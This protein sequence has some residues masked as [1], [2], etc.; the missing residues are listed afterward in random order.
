MLV[1][2][3]I[4]WLVFLCVQPLRTQPVS[5]VFNDQLVP[6]VYITIA[7]DS[8]AEIMDPANAQSDHEY[9]ADFVFSA[10]T[11]SDTV[12]NIGFRLRGNTSR[13]AQKK[14]FKV[15]FNTFENGRKFYGF[16]KLNLNG[17]HNDPSIIRAK[18]AWDIFKQDQ[19]PASL[20]NHIRLFINHQYYGLYINVEHIDENFINN[21][22]GSNSGNLYKCL[23]PAD[24]VYLGSNPESYK[25]ESGGRRTYDLKTNTEADDYSDLAEFITLVHSIPQAG[26][27]DIENWFDVDLYLRILAIDVVTGDWDDYWYLKNNFYLYHDPVEDRFKFIPYDYD[28]TFGIDWVGQDWG[29]RNLYGWGNPWE[30]RPLAT[31][32]FGVP[33]YKDRYSYYIN[34]LLQGA[35]QPDSLFPKIDALHNMISAAA[36]ADTWRT[37]DYGYTVNDFHLSYIQALNDGHTDYGLK[38]YITTRRNSLLSQIQLNDIVPVIRNAVFPSVMVPPGQAIPVSVYVEDEDRQPQVEAHFSVNG[39]DWAVLV[40]DDYDPNSDGL[41]GDH[42]Y[43]AEIPAVDKQAIIQLF[44][45]ARDNTQKESRMPRKSPDITYQ[46]AV[47]SVQTGLFINEFMASNQSTVSDEA[48]EFDDWV[49]LYNG[50]GEPI[51]LG[52]FYL[53]DNISNPSKF[54]LPEMNI[55]PGGFLLVWTDDD[56]EQGALHA[57]YKLDADG[58]E[59]GLFLKEEE[60]FVLLDSITF[61]EQQPNISLG[62]ST[63][64]GADWQFFAAPTPGGSNTP[65]GVKT[66]ESFV[67]AFRLYPNYPNPFNPSTTVHFE[68]GQSSAVQLTIYNTLGQV[69]K[70][71]CYS[72][73]PAGNHQFTWDGK[74]EDGTSLPSGIYIFKLLAHVP[75]NTKTVVEKTIKL[76]LIR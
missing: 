54:R 55:A 43:Q 9:P 53:S 12:E 56:T 49:E 50:S 28:N 18:L 41:A 6:T 22:F 76:M 17:E 61:G 14:S 29:N 19:I 42:I 36:E 47:G 40:M 20:A 34:K 3:M 46:I 7:P 63:D 23:W 60:S 57:P 39:G 62:R 24:L 32:I 38:P 58:E 8:L 74:N 70:M 27:T 11:I 75:G 4:S 44:F 59:L 31:K 48:G 67:N 26:F 73:L 52:N 15:S 65:N 66:K 72:F 68:L 16:E 69:M 45:S 10:G 71:V 1:R 21:R 2:F 13:D 25:F 37:L 51:A 64:G 30:A 35:F 5:A 33:E